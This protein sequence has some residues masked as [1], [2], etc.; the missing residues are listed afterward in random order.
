[1]PMIGEYA[2][3]FKANTTHGEMNFPAD[4]EGEWILFFSHPSAFT[5][6]C[7]SEFIHMQN[8]INEFNKI[9]CSLVGL[10][11]DGIN[12]QYEWVRSI[13]DDI[14]FQGLKDIEIEFPIIADSDKKIANL[15]GMIHPHIDSDK[16]VRSVFVID[17]AGMV[18]A[19]MYYPISTGRNTDELIRL[20]QALQVTDEYDV[21]TPSCWK[22]GDDVFIPPPHSGSK[23]SKEYAEAEEKGDCPAWFMCLKKLPEKKK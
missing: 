5:P 12:T 1:M 3:E 10:S 14:E 16:T 6:V 2:P 15:Y 18:R 22:P 4:Y 20:V 23:A 11:T 21:A 13:R 17:P 19:I 9:N 8:R 7:T